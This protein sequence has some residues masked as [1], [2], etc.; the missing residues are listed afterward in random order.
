MARRAV[1]QV[2]V[3]HEVFPGDRQEHL[4]DL[5][6][7]WNDAV[8]FAAL[9]S[10]RFGLVEGVSPDPRPGTHAPYGFLLARG[11]GIPQGHQG[12]GHLTD[13]AATVLRLLG[14]ESMADM[15]GRPS[16][17][18]TPEAATRDP[19]VGATT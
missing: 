1:S 8:Q 19:R 16:A 7:T 2:W 17:I 18:L 11:A 9:A 6:V 4:P 15:D 13:V 3:R 10:P 14:L 12:Y 5:I